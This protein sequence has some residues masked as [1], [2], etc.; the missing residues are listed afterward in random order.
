V[1]DLDFDDLLRWLEARSGQEVALS[2]GGPADGLGNTQLIVHGVLGRYDGDHEITLVDAA[3]GRVERYDVG[4][5]HLVLLEGDLVGASGLRLGPEDDGEPA[6]VVV[7]FGELAFTVS[8]A[9]APPAS[10]TEA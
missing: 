10:Q 4:D 8:C 7:D 5:A 9:P 3:P 6:H 1:S 2:L